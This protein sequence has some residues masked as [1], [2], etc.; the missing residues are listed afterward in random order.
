MKFSLQAS[1]S[2]IYYRLIR[3]KN[4]RLYLFSLFL[5]FY[6]LFILFFNLKPRVRVSMMSHITEKCRRF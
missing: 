5:L 6:F 2:Y 3:I 1:L 4:N